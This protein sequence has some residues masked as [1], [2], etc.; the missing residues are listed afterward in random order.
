MDTEFLLGSDG[1]VLE[2]HSGNNYTSLWLYERQFKYTLWK[3]ELYSVWI[4]S[5]KLD[6]VLFDLRMLYLNNN[7]FKVQKWR[8]HYSV[9][10]L[11]VLKKSHCQNA[12]TSMTAPSSLLWAS[13][14]FGPDTLITTYHLESL[15]IQSYYEDQHACISWRLFRYAAFQPPRPAT[16]DSVFQKDCQGIHMHINVWETLLLQASPNLL[17]LHPLPTPEGS[18]YLSPPGVHQHLWIQC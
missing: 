8:C 14:V 10:M 2:L 7:F 1:N 12:A 9:A 13:S 11:L 16:S 4:V 17:L 3:G 18:F 5:Q 6:L 15:A